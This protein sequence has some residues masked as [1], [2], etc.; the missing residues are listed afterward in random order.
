MCVCVC[1]WSCR[2]G[3]KL[4]DSACGA[5]E[6]PKDAPEVSVEGWNAEQDSFAFAYAH[7]LGELLL[8]FPLPLG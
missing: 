8:C 6:L 4:L 1:V 7:H 2:G 3:S 5:A